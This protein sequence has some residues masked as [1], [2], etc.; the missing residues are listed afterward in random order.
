[1]TPDPD[2]LAEKYLSAV[3]QFCERVAKVAPDQLDFRPDASTWSA[4]DIAFHVATVDQV[5]G[6]RLRK[7]IAEPNPTMGSMDLDAWSRALR[8]AHGDVGL[9]L[10]SLRATSALNIA[11]IE[12]LTP[13]LMKRTGMRREGHAISVR[14]LA[15]YLAIHIEAHI[16][17]VGRVLSG[18]P[19]T[20]RG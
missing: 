3:E 19:V 1:M 5:L 20:R 17:Q 11:V 8:P 9:A 4:R 18:R 2:D 16:K 15:A 14:D 6:L 12:M 10:D 13:D 7:L